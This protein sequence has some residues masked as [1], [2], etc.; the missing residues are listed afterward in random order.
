MLIFG[1]QMLESAIQL[2]K[3]IIIFAIQYFEYNCK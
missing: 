2:N 3:I 1:L